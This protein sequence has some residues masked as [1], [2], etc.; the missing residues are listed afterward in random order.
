VCEV[1]PI[2]DRP[3]RRRAVLVNPGARGVNRQPPVDLPPGV[4]LHLQRLRCP[5]SS[6][7]VLSKPRG[8][9]SVAVSYRRVM[10]S[11]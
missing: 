10:S 9:R 6:S 2:T 4:R 3:G 11:N 5:H 7:Q 8:H 1:T